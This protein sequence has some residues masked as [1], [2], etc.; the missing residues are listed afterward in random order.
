MGRT[1]HSYG[2]YDPQ[3]WVIRPTVV[4]S[5]I[6]AHDWENICPENGKHPGTSHKSIALGQN[7]ICWRKGKPVV[8]H[9]WKKGGEKAIRHHE[10]PTA[11]T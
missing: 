1:T 7:R 5:R 2:L 6:S 4:G 8:L 3:L 10:A 11:R 9:R